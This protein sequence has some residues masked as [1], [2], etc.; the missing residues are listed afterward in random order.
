M[1]FWKKEA[2][3]PPPP[4]AIEPPAPRRLRGILACSEYAC[5]RHDGVTCAYVDRRG[6]FCPTAWCPDHQV[7]VEGRVFCRRHARLVAAV[8]GQFQMAQ[9]LPD[10][11]NRSPSLADYVGDALEP[12][13]LELLWGL[14]RPGSNDQVAAEPLRVV[15]PMA[16]GTR[17]WDRT[18]KIFDHTGVIVQVAVEVHEGHDPEVDIK[19]GRTLVGRAIP[20]WIDRRR[21]GLPP[22]SPDEDAAERRRFYDGLWEGAPPRIL[23]EVE[24]SRNVMGYSSGR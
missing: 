17:H 9:A 22:L 13:V 16:G 23:F 7:V 10:L 6:R 15:H 2:E 1:P 12:R 19:V 18:W 14:C 11:D 3:P 20:P 8:G 5:S 24:Q 4:A 21:Q